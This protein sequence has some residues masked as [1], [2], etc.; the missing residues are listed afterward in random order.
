GRTRGFRSRAA[1][2][3]PCHVPRQA[4]TSLLSPSR[5]HQARIKRWP[6]KVARFTSIRRVWA[7]DTYSF[8][9]PGGRMYLFQQKH[10]WLAGVVAGLAMALALPAHAHEPG[11]HD[12]HRKPMPEATLDAQAF[13]EVAQDTVTITLA[14]EVSDPSQEAVVKALSNTLDS[15]MKDA[16]AEGKV[17]SRSGNYRVWPHNDDKGAI[18]NWRGRAEIVLKSTDFAAASALAAKLS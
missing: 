12:A 16:R 8:N 18:T 3:R 11:D 7:H 13:A 2:R 14:T 6:G 17:Q 1:R 10:S 5:R 15:V 4:R 9:S